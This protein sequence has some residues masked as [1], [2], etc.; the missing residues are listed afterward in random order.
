[1]N[2]TNR[3]FRILVAV[4]IGVAGFIATVPASADVPRYQTSMMDLSFD[5]VGYTHSYTIIFNPCDNTFSGTGQ[6]PALPDSLQT[7]ETVSG[8]IIGPTIILNSVYGGPYNPGYTFTFEGTFSGSGWTGV[9]TS[10]GNLPG[11]LDIDVTVKSTYRNHGDF[12][13]QSPDKNDAAHSCIGMP[14]I[15]N[16]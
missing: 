10:Q 9:L 1:M 13:S 14:I 15:S 11:V 2:V 3:I 5:V 7:T 4:G 12:V 6:Y 16:K 8:T